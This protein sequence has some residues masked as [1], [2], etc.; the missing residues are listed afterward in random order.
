M[1]SIAEQLGLPFDPLVRGVSVSS[2][3]DDRCR[4]YEMALRR[5]I[6][7]QPVAGAEIAK[8]ALRLFG[9]G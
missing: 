4:V 5:V 7:E 2:P 6:H 9:E 3:Q 8:A 1:P